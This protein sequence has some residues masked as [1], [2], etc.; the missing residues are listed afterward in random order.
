MSVLLL[1]NRYYR[2]WCYRCNIDINV[3]E[4]ISVCPLCNDSFIENISL[5]VTQRLI[6]PNNFDIMSEPQQQPAPKEITSKFPINKVDNIDNLNYRQC[7]ICLE[8]Y[9]VGDDIK[10]LPCNHYFHVSCLEN[11]FNVGN[12]C[13]ICK[14]KIED[15]GSTTTDSSTEQLPESKKNGMDSRIS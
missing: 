2:Y 6:L 14:Y 13:P 10:Q 15:V 1:V 3:D 5:I 8:D 11:W 9:Q 4:S 12:F 7:S